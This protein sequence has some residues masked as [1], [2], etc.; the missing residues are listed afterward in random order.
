MK[1]V[2]QHLQTTQ[3]AYE[4]MLFETYQRW[5]MDFCLNYQNDLQSILANSKINKY[6]LFE[7]AK[8]EAE[9]LNL[10]SRYEDSPTV[11]AIDA[12]TLYADCTFQIFNRTPKP[13]IQEAKKLKIYDTTRN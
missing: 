10:I 3:E 5:C 2:K 1:T 4:T 6:F 8:C 13:L 7:Y 11:T 12:R 9:F